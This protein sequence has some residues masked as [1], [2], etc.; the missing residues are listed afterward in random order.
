MS[1]SSRKQNVLQRERGFALAAVIML[2]FVLGA[3]GLFG[4]V[5]ARNESRTYLRTTTK[6]ASFYAAEAGLGLAIENW[7]GARAATTPPGSTT[8]LSQGSLPGGYQYSAQV[9]RLDDGSSVHPLFALRST[10]QARSG[11]SDQVGLL[12]TSVPL[13]I[14]INYA[15]RVRGTTRIRGTAEV[16][17]ND[18]IPPSL[19]AECPPADTARPGIIINDSTNLDINGTPTIDGNPPITEDPDTTSGHFFDFGGM[20]FQEL[21]RKANLTLDPNAI[22]SG[23]DPGPTL[24][25]DGSCNTSDATNW[26]D[27]TNLGQPCSDWFPIIYAK[28]NLTLSGSGAGQGI[29]VVNGDLDLSG[30][31]EF[32]GPVI[33]KGTLKSTGGGFHIY[34]GI[35]AGATDVSDQ[36]FLGGNSQLAFSTCALRRAVSHSDVATPKALSERAWYQ[37]R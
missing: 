1:V 8:V 29:L 2:I 23:T 4:V 24:N 14:P 19:S 33:V 27:P 10:A 36:S 15:L 22:L 9:L 12:V 5:L 32:Y 11:E 26:G 30:G 18:N 37:T 21:S 7:A 16:N 31:V 17:G 6:A 28:G 3:L 13:E 35:V 34:G 25:A 20:S